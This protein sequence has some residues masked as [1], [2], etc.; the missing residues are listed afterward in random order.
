MDEIAKLADLEAKYLVA[1]NFSIAVDLL[2]RGEADL[3]PN[4]GILPERLDTFSFTRPLETFSVSLFVRDSTDDLRSTDD[5]VG[6]SLAV[7]E[8]NIGLFMF[9]RRKDIDVHVYADARSA[10]FDLLR[11]HVDAF[12]YPSSV[13]LSLARQV[14]VEERIKVV[15]SPLKEVKRGIRVMKG[16][17][18]L[19]ARLDKAVREFVGTTNYQRIYAKWYGTPKP[20][21]T[22]RRAISV[23]SAF[24]VLTLLSFLGW[25]Y[26]FTVRLNRALRDSEDRYA[27]AV[28]GSADGLWDWNIETGEDYLSPRWKEILGYQDHE[29]DNNIATFIDALHPND[30]ERVEKAIAAHLENREPYDLE[31]RLRAKDG[32]FVW[33]NARGQAIWDEDGEPRRMAGSISDISERIATEQKLRSQDILLSSFIDNSPALI[34]LKDLDGRFLRA[35]K[36]F[37]ESRNRPIDEIIGEL[38]SSFVSREHAA[39][40]EA[41]SQVVIRTGE[42]ITEERNIDDLDGTS[43][44]QIVTNF[45]A[46][47]ETGELFGIGFI[48]T[49][50]GELKRSE[51]ALRNSERRF[52][53]ILEIAPD[54]II[55]IDKDQFIHLF[56]DGAEKT[57]GYNADEV[58]G[59]PI[60]ILIPTR[61]RKDHETH[62]RHFEESSETSRLMSRRGEITGLRKNGT[63]FPAEAS[64]SKLQVG[65]EKIFTVML[66]DVTE[67]RRIENQSRQALIEAEEANKGKSEFLAAMS[68][69]LRT[70]LNAILGFSD[71]LSHQY[72][73]QIGVQKYVD[74]A[75]DIHSSGEHLLSLINDVLDI[76]AIEAGKVDLNMEQL[77]IDKMIAECVRIIAKDAADRGIELATS[78][79]NDLPLLRADKRAIRQ[80]LLNLLSNALKHTPEGGKIT[81]SARRSN[82][83]TLLSIADT[84]SGIPPELVSNLTEPFTRG[85]RDPHKAAEGWGLGLAI[86]KSLIDLHGGEI[87][88]ESTVGVGTTVSVALPHRLA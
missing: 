9:G 46:Y 2:K 50:I 29:L 41:Q 32:S 19:L 33:V 16:K 75:Q 68:H 59:R 44:H 64:I 6:R 34:G 88:I 22:V 74:Y 40:I 78:S 18:V 79:S 10:L 14:G 82:S 5:L 20:F 71:I 1:K 65:N 30:R 63:E 8:K 31:F 86:T 28:A 15:G 35:N 12:V 43:Y 54:A 23:M 81:V 84:G 36:A 39:V 85:E 7:V 56:N 53:G 21:W 61:F 42:A 25:H 70:P 76:S 52:A 62:V 45:P 24:L 77:S 27:V 11:G 73:G 69:E 55:S 72:L 66:Q 60:D 3:I 26:R 87:D 4:S 48:S 37:A 67:R 13:L 47:D 80:I 38:S 17:D 51:E 83:K 58:I 57:F 49:D